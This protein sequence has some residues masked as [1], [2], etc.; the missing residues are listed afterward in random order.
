MLYDNAQLVSLY[1]DAYLVYKNEL[2]KETAY[3]TLDFIEREL[4]NDEGAF[5]SS[6]DADSYNKTGELEEGAFYVWTAQELRSLLKNDY[7]LF[8]EY[9]NNNNNSKWE[10]EN[11][12][13]IRTLDAKAF[14][15]KH[16]LSLNAFHKKERK[17]QNY[18]SKHVVKENVHV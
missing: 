4:T 18:F 15:T 11:Y 10:G 6:L 13:L 3:R 9:Y 1:A 2:Y 14:A 8:S 5:Y 16:K 7:G 12:H 17:W